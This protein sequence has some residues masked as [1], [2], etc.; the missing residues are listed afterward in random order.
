MALLIAGSVA[1]GILMVL[2]VGWVRRSPWWLSDMMERLVGTDW[3][4]TD[5]ELDERARLEL[6]V[7]QWLRRGT[8]VRLVAPWVEIPKGASGMITKRAGPS[9]LI[10]WDGGS[11]THWF[12]L[13]PVTLLW[14]EPLSADF[15]PSAGRVKHYA[16]QLPR[17]TYEGGP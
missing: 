10:R 16:P 9:V 15:A 6:R 11:L 13:H 1:G 14:L 12:P 17:P 2:L 3:L 7:R 5:G 4:E 8:R